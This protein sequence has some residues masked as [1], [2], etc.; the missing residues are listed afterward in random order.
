MSPEKKENPEKNDNEK[1]GPTDAVGDEKSTD[2]PNTESP[3][4]DKGKGNIE[5]PTGDDTTK[6]AP[7]S[8]EIVDSAGDEKSVEAKEPVSESDDKTTKKDSEKFKKK[9]F[10]GGKDYKSKDDADFWVP[11][12]RLGKLVKDGKITTIKDA[13][14]TGLRIREPEIIDILLPELDDEVLD[15]NM[16][17]R[18]TDSGRR[19]RFAIMTVVG[20]QNGYVGLG[21]SKGK[22]VGPSIRKAID[23]AKLNIIEIRRGCGSWECGCNAP[24]SIPF[25][26]DGK[27]GSTKVTF[28]P[29]P[30]GVGLAVGDVA[31]HILRLS[32]IKDTWGF[33]RGET[34][35]TIN[36]AKAVFKALQNTAK[37]KTTK[38]Q[39]NNL[40][41][42][43]GAVDIEPEPTGTDEDDVSAS[44]N[45]N[46]R[47]A[48]QPETS[49]S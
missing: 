25:T 21:S 2:S 7:D 19:V 41:I 48:E 44:S 35:T 47:A 33:T 29:A 24:H 13:L 31:K 16:V 18:M 5:S 22:E 39:I 17:Q 32:G 46:N 45:S 23:N 1:S 30:R 9:K 14:A 43:S 40:H 3:N 4:E 20:N 49:E 6:P 34:R 37:L 28:R 8:P 38:G 26:V 11:K 10:E 27:S 42:I 15:V 12:T 36:Y